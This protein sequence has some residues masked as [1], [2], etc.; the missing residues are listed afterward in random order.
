MTAKLHMSG[1]VT[2]TEEDYFNEMSFT[3]EYTPTQNLLCSHCKNCHICNLLAQLV[4]TDPFANYVPS[5]PLDTGPAGLLSL[6]RSGCGT[7]MK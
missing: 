5:T 2:P 7:K 4:P 3:K 6:G 1:E